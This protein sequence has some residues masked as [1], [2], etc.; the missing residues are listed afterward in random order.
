[1]EF[2]IMVMFILAVFMYSVSLF[3]SRSGMNVSFYKNW[4]AD[5]AIEIL[6]ANINSA[7]FSEEGTTVYADIIFRNENRTISIFGKSIIAAWDG[8]STSYPIATG[9]ITL[10]VEDYNGRISFTKQNGG[11]VVRNAQ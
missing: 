1:M 4:T 8:G 7:W 11:V 9:N 3:L 5:S 10:E 2:M 6:G